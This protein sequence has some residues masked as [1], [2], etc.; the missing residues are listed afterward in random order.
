MI[1]LFCS[2]ELLIDL[3]SGIVLFSLINIVNC[4]GVTDY[5]KIKIRVCDL[6]KALTDGAPISKSNIPQLYFGICFGMFISFQKGHKCIHLYTRATS[7]AILILTRMSA[8]LTT[9]WKEEG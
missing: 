7:N 3:L 2:F 1:I 4:L 8:S 9:I 6:T 5:P